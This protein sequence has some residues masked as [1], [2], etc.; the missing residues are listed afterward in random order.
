MLQQ[1]GVQ[2]AVGQQPHLLG[3]RQL[4]QVQP[5]VRAGA[6]ELGQ[7][8]PGQF[9]RHADPQR[10]DLTAVRLPDQRAHP[11]PPGQQVTR[12]GEQ[13][14]AGLGQFDA[15]AVAFEQPR[16]EVG[17]EPADALAQW[18]LGDAEPVRGASEVEFFG[19]HDEVAQRAQ[20]RCDDIRGRITAGQDWSWTV[21]PVPC[22]AGGMTDRLSRRGV[23]GAG[24]GADPKTRLS[25]DTVLI[26]HILVTHGHY[27][28][29][30]DVPYLARKTGATVYGT[31]THLNLMAAL[32]APEDQ[33]AVASGDEFLT[34]D[35]SLHSAAG[36]RAAVPFP[37]HGRVP[38]SA[39]YQNRN[40][41]RTLWGVEPSRTT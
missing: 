7:H 32:G 6:T 34:F 4:L 8:P 30:T 37:G 25:V 21:V 13:D 9:R 23:F 35:G 15:T 17:F 41:F 40:T 26:D 12:F 28:H 39:T 20:A 38:G 1:A 10:V 22:W 14:L 36:A 18:R 2:L 3:R 16:A 24:L 5:H 27:D 11:L 31:E 19:D 29:L 33:L